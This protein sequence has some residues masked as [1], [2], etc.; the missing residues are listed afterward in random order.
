M[1]QLQKRPASRGST[2]P[3]FVYH[4]G[5]YPTAT[6]QPSLTEWRISTSISTR[7]SLSSHP[8][9]GPCPVIQYADDTMIIVQADEIQLTRLKEILHSFSTATGLHINYEKS[10][11][12][13]IH[14]DDD[15][16][17]ALASAFGCSV[18]TV[19]QPYLGLPLSNLKLHLSD[20]LPTICRHDK[21]LS[22]WKGPLLNQMARTTLGLLPPPSA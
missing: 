21:Y 20:F 10:T 5:R 3:I 16:A 6:H 12:L 1:D 17:S 19:P 2:L 7:R 18:S 9:C 15:R 13:P 14:V 4:C 8:V 22:G 11:F